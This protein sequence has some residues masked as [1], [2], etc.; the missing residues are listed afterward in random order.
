EDSNSTTTPP[1]PAPA[2]GMPGERLR[3]LAAVIA[4]AL[5]FGA[6]VAIAA[7]LDLGNTRT[8][9]ELRATD[10]TGE[11]FDGASSQKAAGVALL[12]V[13]GLLGAVAVIMGL[14]LAFDGRF[15]RRFGW[16]A[17]AAVVAGALATVAIR[18]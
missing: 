18:I 17:G 9:G 13:S 14:A 15:G 4:I 12:W 2:P 5:S 16:F 6:A 3:A 1:G 11:C 7:A 8:C 10:G